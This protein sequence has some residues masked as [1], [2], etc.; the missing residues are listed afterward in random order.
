MIVGVADT[1]VAVTVVA[2]IVGVAVT[3]AVAVNVGVGVAPIIPRPSSSTCWGLFFAESVNVRP[4]LSFTLPEAVGW[5]TT[6]TS[7]ELPAF[8]GVLEHLSL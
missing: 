2:V 7:H 6:L 5:N 1:G 3:V 4:F 8:S